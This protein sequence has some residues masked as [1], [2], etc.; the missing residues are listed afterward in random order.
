MLTYFHK[1]ME[2]WD[3]GYSKTLLKSPTL[4]GSVGSSPT[5]SSQARVAQR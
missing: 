5:S 4:T 3:N 2:D 1:A